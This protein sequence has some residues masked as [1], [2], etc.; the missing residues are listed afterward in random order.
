MV[1]TALPVLPDHS[2]RLYNEGE[3]ERPDFLY[4]TI[5]YLYFQ[6]GPTGGIQIVLHKRQVHATDK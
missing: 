2:N 6:F 4:N 3:R 5:Q 1:V